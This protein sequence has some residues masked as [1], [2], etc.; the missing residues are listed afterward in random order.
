[1]KRALLVGAIAI[2]S[3]STVSCGGDSSTSPADPQVTLAIRM[4]ASVA[5]GG[6]V[7]ASV[8]STA[9]VAIA[10]NSETPSIASVSSDGR[11][12][13]ASPGMARISANA[14]KVKTTA[15]LTVLPPFVDIVLGGR[16]ACARSAANDLFCWG[17]DNNAQLGSASTDEICHSLASDVACS[18]SPRRNPGVP[19]VIQLSAQEDNTCGLT[20]DGAAFCW[21]ANGSGQLGLTSETCE[22]RPCVRQALRVAPALKFESFGTGNTHFC[23]LTKAGE[24]YCWG[25]NSLGQVGAEVSDQCADSPCSLTPVRIGRDATYRALSVG[26][27]HTC[28]LDTAGKAF[29]WGWNWAGQL[30]NG[31]TTPGVIGVP[32]PT[33]VA[34]GFAFTVIST[35]R[36]HTCALDANGAAYCW[37]LNS[38][39]QL[40][41]GT[42]VSSSVPRA[43]A[44]GHK[45]VSISEGVAHTCALTSGGTAHC[46]GANVAE[47]GIGGQ[48][49]DGSLVDRS[50]PTEV[51]RGITFA[52]LRTGRSF[53]CGRTPNNRVYCWG[54]NLYGQLG[55]GT[56]QTYAAQ[57]TGVAGLP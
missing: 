6:I 10:W 24:V 44:G 29:C 49:G 30:G 40:G 26:S 32:A 19:A 1:M 18:K 11:I 5:V 8:S 14:G 33:A 41:D 9:N 50:T 37:G 53:S 21:G 2:G 51:Q 46:W 35:G 34:G 7:Q 45:F 16:H 55:I 22:T 42:L 43:V 56:P 54:S 36:D 47:P 15:E 3:Q 28:A 57:P 52:Q 39:G 12:T 4:P 25:V 17:T 20:D 27:S 23:G 31:A 48:V 38:S 13:G